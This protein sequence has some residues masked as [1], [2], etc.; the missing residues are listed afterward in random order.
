MSTT[1]SNH[2]PPLGEDPRIEMALRG[3]TLYGDDFSSSEIE[4]WFDDEREGYFDLYYGER[5][6][7]ETAQEEYS[8]RELAKQHGFNWLPADRSF[9]QA[10]GIGSAT[11]SELDPVLDRC[12]S[13]TVLEPSGGFAT[14]HRRGK[15]VHYVQPQSSGLMPFEDQSFDLIVCFSVLHHVPNVSTV[16]KEMCRVLKPGGHVLLREPT[17][18]MGDWRQPRPGLTKRE[19]GIPLQVFRRMVDNAGLRVVAET[20]CNFSLMSRLQPLLS[21][22]V[23]SVPWLVKLDAWLCRQKFWPNHYH[24]T[25]A[26]Q[27]LRP[28]SVAYVL[29]R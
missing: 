13:V 17:C 7:Q 29:Q 6:T 8:Y 2:T 10:L 25:N 1:T 16:L 24:A 3:A 26:W 22:P 19:R 21:Q 12:Q 14:T 27:K 15:P 4:A 11:G 23:W 18:S 9:N 5:P 20:R 28:I